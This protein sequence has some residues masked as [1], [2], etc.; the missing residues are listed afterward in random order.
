MSFLS[1]NV[2]ARFNNGKFYVPGPY[3]DFFSWGS[4]KK[5]VVYKDFFQ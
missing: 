3:L 2:E 5:I 4:K 1:L